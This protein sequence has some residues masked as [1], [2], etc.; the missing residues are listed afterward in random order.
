VQH[1]NLKRTRTTMWYGF[2]RKCLFEYVYMYIYI[3]LYV[4]IMCLHILMLFLKVSRRRQ[5]SIER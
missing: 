1:Y 2:L 5:C 3:Y 4:Y